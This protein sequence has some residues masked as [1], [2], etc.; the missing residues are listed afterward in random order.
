MWAILEGSENRA[1]E[2]AVYLLKYSLPFWNTSRCRVWVQ[3]VWRMQYQ[4]QVPMQRNFH[5][6]PTT[7][8][9][10]GW[11]G[12]EICPG[13]P[14]SI[15]LQSPSKQGST[16]ANCVTACVTAAVTW[17]TP[18]WARE[19]MK[20]D[21]VPFLHEKLPDLGFSLCSCMYLVCLSPLPLLCAQ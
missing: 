4:I 1:A 3:T 8:R 6:L 17:L 9:I 20:G 5:A 19:W 10:L 21:R 11:V 13:E 18:V 2:N 15:R 12:A 7:S 14:S 16:S